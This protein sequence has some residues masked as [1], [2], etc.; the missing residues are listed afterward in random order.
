MD[1]L[2]GKTDLIKTLSQ[3]MII[4]ILDVIIIILSFI[5]Q[6]LFEPRALIPLDVSSIKINR[7]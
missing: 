1:D 4:S 3:F 6:F 5:R 7:G 2:N